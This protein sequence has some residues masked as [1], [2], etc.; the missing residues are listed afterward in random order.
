MARRGT[1]HRIGWGLLVGS[2]IMAVSPA[3]AEMPVTFLA[4]DPVAGAYYGWGYNLTTKQF[5]APCLTYNASA[6]YMSGDPDQGSTY[7]FVENTSEI[8]SKSNL[9]V[10]AALKVLAAGGTYNVD[11]KTEV[12]AGTQ[13]STYSQALFANAYRYDIPKFLDIGQ[14]SFK[15]EARRLL[16]TSG[17]KGQF[18]QQCGD[19]FV[20]G[21]Q[22]GREFIG[23]ATITRQN[24]KSWTQ[25]A[26]KTGSSASGAWGTASASVD[27]GKLLE[28]TFGSQN[29]VVKTYSTGSSRP[30]PTLA[31]E[32]TT[33]FQ[34]F[35]SS[36]GP[37]KTVKLIVAPYQL[38][39]DYPWENPLQET[40]KEDYIGM[41][42]A[43]L[44]ELKAAIR[45]ADFVI[46]PTTS[47]MFALGTTEA[48][49]KE[50][51]DYIR[52]TRDAW[53]TEYDLLLKAAQQCND[54][55]TPSCKSL[56]E[57]YD[58][59]RNLAAQRYAVLP[60][61]YL[62]DCKQ[63]IVLTDV[64][65]KLKN[66]LAQRN[67]GTPLIGDAETAGSPSR[68]AA[69]LVFRPDKTQLKAILS[70]MKMEWH[71]PFSPG[72]AIEPKDS[73]LNHYSTWGMQAQAT[74]F[75]LENP[76]QY[77]GGTENLKYCSW[78]GDGVDFPNFAAPSAHKSLHQFGF[79]QRTIHGYI[80]GKS[81]EDPRGQVHFGNGRGAL[82]YITCEVDRKGDDNNMQ[83]LDLGLRNV[84][85]ALVST[86]DQEADRWVT[87]SVKPELPTALASFG[88]N[89]A[90]TTKD[91][92]QF[93]PFMAQ[94]SPE[95]KKLLTS[96]ETRRS[97]TLTGLKGTK[98]FKLPKV[99]L[100]L[101][102]MRTKPISPNTL[103]PV[104]PLAA[105]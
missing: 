30:N 44:W 6:T 86:Q 96:Y 70:V 48:R 95:R 20:I 67:F 72:E 91:Q 23:T 100:D 21:I 4:V 24:L 5:T 19:G 29:I 37:E 3:R 89:Q 27:I 65:Q 55:F 61:R 102:Q 47:N 87:P 60:D 2:F 9:S 77:G 39:G 52:Q 88:R 78:K 94:L 11:N 8:V 41:F 101:I 56:A 104:A 10:S 26:S 1:L 49:K 51:L 84:A 14:V 74:V 68:V 57:F 17:G 38:V 98:S 54:Q 97:A 105:P 85:L 12:A 80:D 32:L 36:T 79:G 34:N 15:P 53:Q 25:F 22:S 99:Q 13:S 66:A 82:E 62:S 42:V 81:G 28:Q 50:R 45:D 16:T 69:E 58:R 7:Q 40:G 93:K 103:K 33:Y 31:S 18:K 43:G 35:L 59:S 92:E 71:K 90:V 73:N 83:C 75:D 46:D 64:T 76:Q 63:K